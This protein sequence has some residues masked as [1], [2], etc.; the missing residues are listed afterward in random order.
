[1]VLTKEILRELE[2]SL[3]IRLTQEQ[4]AILFLWYGSEPDK[5]HS[6]EVNDFVYGIRK[7]QHYYPNHRPKP[8]PGFLRKDALDLDS[9]EF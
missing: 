9:E 1:M 2:E 4:R 7:V 8:A 3:W 5:W 6:W